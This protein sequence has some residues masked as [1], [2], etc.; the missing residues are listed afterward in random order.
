MKNYACF[1]VGGTFIKYGAIRED[2]LILKKGKFKTP[3]SNCRKTIPED[4]IMHINEIKESFDIA[5]AGISTAG[6]VD[7]TKGEVIYATD[8]LPD[9][10]GTKLYELIKN[11]T[12]LECAVENDVN[13][14]A[15]GEMWKGAGINKKNFVCITLGTGIGGA[16]IIGGRLY[17]GTSGSAGEVGHIIINEGGEKCTCGGRGCFERYASTSALVRNYIKESN[18]NENIDGEEILRRVKNGDKTAAEVYDEFLDHIVSGILSI[19][20]ILNPELIIIGGGISNQGKPFFD[21][22]NRRFKLRGMESFTSPADIVQ[23][24][25]TND[26]GL[27]GACYSVQVKMKSNM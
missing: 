25:L 8:N 7:S 23:A 16:L 4:I 6:Q 22:I 15:L 11:E 14:A 19:T 18:D 9:Y 12:G 13:A 3:D 21:E 26:A 24:E 27:L 2:G 5:A 20:Y 17:R 10:T 1:D